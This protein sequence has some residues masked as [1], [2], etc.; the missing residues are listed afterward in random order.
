MTPTT[1]TS[2]IGPDGILTVTVPFT[3]AEANQEVKLTIEP[4][5]SLPK[6]TPEETREWLRSLAGAWQGEFERP[7][8]Q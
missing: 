8:S 4:V 5:T 3:H 1:L 2:R 7:P 6:K